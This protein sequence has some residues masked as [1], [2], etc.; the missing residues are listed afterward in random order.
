MRTFIAIEI[1]PSIKEK[2]SE[3]INKLSQT[4]ARVGWVKK[5]SIHLTLKFLGEVDEKKIKEV[6]ERLKEI[7]SR[8][9]PFKI[10]IEGAGWFPEGSLNPRVL[11]IGIKYPEQ[12]RVLWK[13]IEKEMKEL[14]F[15]EEERDFSPHITIGRVKEKERISAVLEILKKFMTTFFGETE[16]KSIVLFKSVLKPDGAE[17]TPIEKFNFKFMN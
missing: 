7:S 10:R 4:G 9:K 6:S 15:K 8:T 12:L 3:L 2:I 17:Y 16:V 13:G 5:E 14:G 11:W 1:E